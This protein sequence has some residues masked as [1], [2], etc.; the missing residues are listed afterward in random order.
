M[1]TL[2]LIS[3]L[4]LA[5][6]ALI[7]LTG[8]R[9]VALAGRAYSWAFPTYKQEL[10]VHRVKDGETLYGIAARYAG[11]QDKWDDLRGVVLDIQDA[12]GIADNDARWLTPGRRIL[13]P[14][15]KEVQNP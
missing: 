15:K 1:K 11:Q 8:G 9:G 10:L 5:L 3:L 12:N 14:L 2:K 13:V 6:A 4:A 7:F